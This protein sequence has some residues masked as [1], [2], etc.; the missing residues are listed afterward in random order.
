MMFLS[1]CAALDQV[2]AR[3]HRGPLLK[4]PWST[5]LESRGARWHA[6]SRS[7]CQPGAT[8]RICGRWAFPR[9]TDTTFDGRLHAKGEWRYARSGRGPQMA[10]L[11]TADVAQRFRSAMKGTSHWS[12]VENR[13]QLLGATG[14]PL[15]MF[16]RGMQTP[17]S[18]SGSPLQGT[19]WQLVKFR[20]ATTKRSRR[21]RRSTASTSGVAGVLRL[22]LTATVATEPGKPTG[23]I[24]SNLGLSRSRVRNARRARCTIRSSS[25]GPTFGPSSSRMATSFWC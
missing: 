12:M 6:R 23:R 1:C 16:E 17:S 22:V 13:V 14:K 18:T 9:M 25:S 20:E 5:L 19:M 11:D 10:C 3:P 8:P 15:A 7:A 24:N 21:T 2:R 4:K